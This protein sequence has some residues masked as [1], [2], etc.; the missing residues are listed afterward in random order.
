MVERH[1]TCMHVYANTRT[2]SNVYISL[3][4]CLSI[5]VYVCAY[6]HE[7]KY[8]KLGLSNGVPQTPTDHQK[9][10]KNSRGNIWPWPRFLGHKT[11]TQTDRSVHMVTYLN[12]MLLSYCNILYI[13]VQL[14]A[15]VQAKVRIVARG[16]LLSHAVA[17]I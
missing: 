13:C 7:C 6:A 16:G 12:V 11:H 5:H 3:L 1:H 9:S 17:I 14:C 2:S 4:L 8:R 10:S 15:F